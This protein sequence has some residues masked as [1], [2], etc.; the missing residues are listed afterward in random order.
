M[1][2]L[3][4]IASSCGNKG[5]L[6][7]IFNKST[8]YETYQQSLKK[9]NLD[10]TV[11]GAAWV[12]EGK[13]V[14]DDSL[15]VTLP[16]SEEAYFEASA[17]MA[18]GYRFIAERGQ[19]LII[20]LK[21]LSREELTIFID[22]FLIDDEPEHLLAADTTATTMEYEVKKDGE[23]LLRLQ[24]ELLREG[25]YIL[26]VTSNAVLSFPILEKDYKSIASFFGA[27]R[28][29]G[30]RKHEGVDVFAP[31]KT[32]VLAVTKGRVTRVN[33]NRLGGKVVWQRD[34]ER[35]LSYYY[36]HLDSQ[37]VNSGQNVSVGDTV[38]L[39]GNTGNAITT[40]PHLH[41][42]IYASGYGAI[43]PYAFFHTKNTIVSSNHDGNE[44]IGKTV[45]VNAANINFRIT[46]DLKSSLIGKLPKNTLL[47]VRSATGQWLR[48]ETGDQIEGYVHHSLV[49][50]IDT[51]IEH[52]QFAHE[53]WLYD[54][55]GDE[56]ILMQKIPS[57]ETVSILAAH[58][59]YYYVSVSDGYGWIEQP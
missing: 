5:T 3:V 34:P 36:A 55:P 29:A 23:Y 57:G 8:P 22:L 19:K 54:F 17:I 26:S 58:E 16:F 50:A 35:N 4:V 27:A 24:P 21:V 53:S 18:N 41:F 56:R 40:P 2:F 6:S 15:Y 47:N 1:A 42:G 45:R 52:I 7:G 48:V 33:T 28:D 20:N 13:A 25:R 49:G 59:N 10:E 12:R 44:L 38:G 46:P 9:A 43:D 31:R 39:V 11:L 30:V 14:F 51:P 37:S 32:P